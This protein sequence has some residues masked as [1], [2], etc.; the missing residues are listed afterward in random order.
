MVYVNRANK[1]SKVVSVIKDIDSI[2]W[3]KL[4][5]IYKTAGDEWEELAQASHESAHDAAYDY[6]ISKKETE[7]G[8]ADPES[9]AYEGNIRDEY[10]KQPLPQLANKSYGRRKAGQK[11]VIENFIKVYNFGDWS[12]ILMPQIVTRLGSMITTKNSKGLISGK[13]FVLDNFKT[14][15]DKGLYVF[16]MLD[17]RSCYL[18]TQYKGPAR[19]YSSLVPLILY[20]VRL[21]KGTRYTAWDPDEIR[22]VVNHELAEAMLFRTDDWP[23]REQLLEGRE[24]GLTINSGKDA[25][26][27]RS[28]LSTFK[29][30]S[31]K[32]TC[33]ENM[34]ACVQLMLAQIWVAHPDNRSKYMVL[35]PVNWDRVPQPL[36]ETEVFEVV[37]K[38]VITDNSPGLPWDL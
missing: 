33:Y 30:Y 12:E 1:S 18:S 6:F 22:Y 5:S 20:A 4:Y 28:A 16:L 13:A 14:D 32:D 11:A 3:D 7:L 15:H 24:Q 29:L 26:K 19:A 34:P 27:K 2:P 25:G 23:T 31:V 35:D 37:V 9:G 38:P 10:P 17:T 36:I 21:V 8:L